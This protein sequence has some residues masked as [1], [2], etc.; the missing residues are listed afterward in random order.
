MFSAGIRIRKFVAISKFH[1]EEGTQS[2]TV[3]LLERLWETLRTYW[4]VRT[5]IWEVLKVF[6]TN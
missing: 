3:I 2:Q 6:L 4:K 1:C 5:G